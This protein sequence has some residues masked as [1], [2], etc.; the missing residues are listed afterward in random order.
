MA[1][2][3]RP[4]RASYKKG[5]PAG[6]AIYI[7]DTEPMATRLMITCLDANDKYIQKE[8]AAESL[9]KE[10][11]AHK[12][13]PVWLSVSGLKNTETIHLL[14]QIL[15]IHPLVIEDLL[16]TEH[17]S[18]VEFFSDYI[19]MITKLPFSPSAY[20][21]LKIEQ[22]SLIIKENL[23]IT[24]Q[25]EH[26]AIMPHLLHKIKEF[27]IGHLV[28]SLIDGIID[29]HYAI[30]EQKGDVLEHL[31]EVIITH[32]KNIDLGDLYSIKRDMLRLRKNVIA[33]NNI[34]LQL[35]REQSRFL[36]GLSEIYLRDL[37]DHLLRISES[38]DIHYELSSNILQVYLSSISNKTNETMKI[39]TLFAAIFIPL[40]FIASVYGMNFAY[41]PG[42]EWEWGYFAAVGGMTALAVGLFIF[43]KKKG[44]V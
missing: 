8:I 12:K 4:K 41:I 18:K 40:S 38:I 14:G 15:E 23:L 27:T 24:F 19:F 30:V 16:N 7:G 44:W 43:F 29:E 22:L 5:I 26:E 2:N 10:L 36:E 3:K 31:E 11:A 33:L 20:L 25:E 35:L 13:R 6:S 39:L 42:L 1:A 37:Q 21:P 9:E 32:K 28:Y 17:L 34:I